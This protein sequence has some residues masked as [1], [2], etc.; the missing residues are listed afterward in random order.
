MSNSKYDKNTYIGYLKRYNGGMKV[1]P[2]DVDNKIIGNRDKILD[3]LQHVFS[4]GKK[5]KQKNIEKYFKA[6][7]GKYIRNKMNLP[8][9]NHT[10]GGAIVKDTHKLLK[11]L[12]KNNHS[13]DHVLDVFKGSAP[14]LYDKLESK[15]TGGNIRDTE[16]N[17]SNSSRRGL[18]RSDGGYDDY[19]GLSRYNNRRPVFLPSGGYERDERDG[20][21]ERRYNRG[22]ERDEEY[23]SDGGYERYPERNYHRNFDYYPDS[24]HG[25]ELGVFRNEIGRNISSLRDEIIN[26]LI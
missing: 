16:S 8:N 2:G 23:E 19:Y 20:G 21:Y 3:H 24:M 11:L 14:Q 15:I 9:E 13:I 25:G 5:L 26:I 7:G 6:L 1:I 12:A 18:Y 4:G 10:S 17:Y 22:Y